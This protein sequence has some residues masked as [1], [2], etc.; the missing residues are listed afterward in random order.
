MSASGRV[1][2]V[3]QYRSVTFVITHTIKTGEE[4]RHEDWAKEMLNASSSYPGYLGRE[5]FRL[6]AGSR[7]YTTYA[8][9]PMKTPR[10]RL[11]L[12]LDHYKPVF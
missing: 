2:A 3:E 9:D 7:N 11:Q 6:A 10:P 4:K 8:S 5:V 1:A 12:V